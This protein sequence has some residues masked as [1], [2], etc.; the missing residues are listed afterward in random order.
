[1]A[2]PIVI[3]RS[4][5]RYRVRVADF[6]IGATEQALVL[7]EAGHDPVIYVPRADMNMAA[8]AATARHTTCPWKGE[9]SYFS[10]LTPAGRL[11]N[12]VWSYG[13]PIPARAEIAGHLAFYPT[14]TV[15]KL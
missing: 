9:A 10:I 13:T 7:D 5:Q 1:M 2:E 14:V 8:L 4:S 3:T 12:A 6:V 15:E 11:E